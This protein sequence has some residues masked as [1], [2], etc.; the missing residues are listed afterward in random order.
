MN[1]MLEIRILIPTGEDIKTNKIQVHR[2]SH[3]EAEETEK[4][5]DLLKQIR[6]VLDN[7]YPNNA[8]IDLHPWIR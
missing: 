6:D 4:V 5:D 7:Y 1:E 8:G 3:G 2:H